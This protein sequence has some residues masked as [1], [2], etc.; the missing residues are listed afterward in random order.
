MILN[1]LQ[2][3]LILNQLSKEP[4]PGKTISNEKPALCLKAK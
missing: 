2:P 4:L 3:E 1:Q